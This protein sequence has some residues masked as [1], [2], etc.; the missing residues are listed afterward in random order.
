MVNKIGGQSQSEEKTLMIILYWGVWWKRLE[1]KNEVQ[2]A[3]GWVWEKASVNI[4][5]TR[6]HT[7]T[8][9]REAKTSDVYW[10]VV[11]KNAH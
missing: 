4:S 5:N 2:T 3:H 9:I 8:I 1:S 6:E 11:I 10:K 7:I